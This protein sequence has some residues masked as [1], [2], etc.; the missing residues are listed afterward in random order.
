MKT[1]KITAADLFSTLSAITCP[2]TAEIWLKT[3]AKMPK[4]YNP[5]GEVFK[6]SKYRIRLNFALDSEIINRAK[7]ANVPLVSP[8]WSEPI[9]GV[10]CYHPGLKCIYIRI[11][12]ILKCQKTAYRLPDGKFVK[13]EILRKYLGK[14][15]DWSADDCTHFV[16]RLSSIMKVQVDDTLYEL[17]E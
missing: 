15:R 13:E 5:V 17:R 2:A 11:F 3:S 6:Y 7:A 9:N 10:F 4:S 1:V 14:P 12:P 8:K 16:C